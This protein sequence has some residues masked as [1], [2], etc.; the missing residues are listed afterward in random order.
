M[1]SKYLKLFIKSR[2]KIFKANLS[3]KDTP[4][5]GYMLFNRFETEEVLKDIQ[6]IS[7]TEPRP[8][9]FIY[10]GMGSQ[11]PGMGKTLMCIPTF[12]DSLKK[13]S[14]TLEKFGLDVYGMLNNVDP[15]QYKNNT[16]NCMLAITAIQVKFLKNYKKYKKLFKR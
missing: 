12:N 9:W 13:S 6:K 10:S 8:I 14:K 3:P 1:S 7:I 16:M 4:I 2:I 11:W 15:A 5:R